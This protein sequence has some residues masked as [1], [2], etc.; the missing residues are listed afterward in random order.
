MTKRWR[1]AQRVLIENRGLGSLRSQLNASYAA[2]GQAEK[3]A[4]QSIGRL[5]DKE[6]PALSRQ[7]S[8]FTAIHGDYATAKKFGRLDAF[9]KEL[10]KSIKGLHKAER[11]LIDKQRLAVFKSAYADNAQAWGDSLGITFG[12][13]NRASLAAFEEMPVLGLPLQQQTQAQAL[14][15]A[16]VVRRQITIGL[17][18]GENPRTVAR[19]IQRVAGIAK[20]HAET[21]ARTSIISA[22]G[23]AEMIFSERNKDIF[24]PNTFRW[25]TAADERTCDI[26]APLH[27][28]IIENP[29][30]PAHFRCRCSI[31]PVMRKELQTIAD[32]YTK[33]SRMRMAAQRKELISPEGTAKRAAFRREQ[34]N[35]AARLRYA[36]DRRAEGLTVRPLKKKDGSPTQWA[37][38]A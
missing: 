3:L 12:G 13:P 17:I 21:L 34:T 33:E 7:V 2:T 31:T 14:Q 16:S 10:D 28:Q 30:H 9:Y 11:A 4:A 1:K 5:F 32:K 6:I 19:R 38:T 26:C 24:K 20:R 29:E 23:Q 35:A 36:R 8:G 27:G 25:Y 18:T 37:K 22:H 15:M